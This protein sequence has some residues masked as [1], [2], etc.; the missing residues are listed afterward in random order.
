M[1]DKDKPA[2]NEIT[3]LLID[4]PGGSTLKHNTD[5]FVKRGLVT[6]LCPACAAMSLYTLQAFSPAGGKGH[7][8]SMRGGGPLSTLVTGDTLWQKVWG[9]VLPLSYRDCPPPPSSDDLPGKVFPWAAP[10]RTS[11]KGETTNPSDVHPLHAYWSMP[12]RILLEKSDKPCACSIC[13]ADSETSVATYLTRP[14]G[15]N[16]GDTWEHPLTP[17]RKQ[18]DKPPFTIKGQSQHHR[19]QQLAGHRVRTARGGRQKAKPGGSGYL[20][21]PR[22]FRLTDVDVNAAGFDMDNMKALQWCEHVFPFYRTR[23]ED[24]FRDYVHRMIQA[25]DKIRSNLVGAVK[26]AVVNEAGKNQ[27]KVDKSFFANVGKAFWA[28]TT[29]RFYAL[30]GDLAGIDN[31]ERADDVLDAWARYIMSVAGKLFDDYVMSAHI[32]PERYERYVE[33]GLSMGR[34]NYS[35]L[36][37]N[38]FFNKGD[39]K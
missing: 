28:E 27:A 37:K 18:T 11:E 16:Y 34:F 8:T 31:D 19:L 3:A 23:E 39:A 21:Q 1:S 9:N 22:T 30:A 24:L 12:R 4:A 14:S 17:Y 6:N 7:R 29:V 2:R 25:A 32:P 36:D 5:F 26:D 33:A 35:Y 13:G 38:G 15:Y 20:C 10:T